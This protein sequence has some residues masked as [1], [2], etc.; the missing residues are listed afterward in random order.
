MSA[1][2]SPLS[3]PEDRP[4]SD[5]ILQILRVV[6]RVAAEQ[7]CPYIVVG[8]TARDLLLY[9]VYGIPASRA[10][11]DV[12]FA[13]AVESWDKFQTLRAALLATGEFA[14]SPV[15]HRL[16]FQTPQ[17]TTDIPID[18]I[19]FGGVAENDMIA[20]P[21]HRDT[22][23]TVAGFEDA[24]ASCVQVAVARDVAIPVVSLAALSV[25]K[26]IAWA[27]RRTSDKDALDLY[28]VISTYADAGNL[29]RLYDSAPGLLEN[30]GYDLEL[31][32]AALAGVDGR[33]LSSAPALARL[34]ILI[35]ESFIDA[36][37]ERIR[38]SRWPL[39]PE[40]LPRVRAIL[41]AWR[42]PLL[43]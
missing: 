16:F 6:D 27:D 34:R 38:G 35:T 4:V 36:L 25:L 9:H 29:D 32:G 28:R 40:L 5:P 15:E 31:A 20:W 22:L 8:A 2:S 21:P 10:T 37:A 19:P 42:D 23:M 18:L 41:Q 12:D 30:F 11:R 39:Q 14:P 33:Q 43:Q 13:M 1:S 24:M 3:V 17:G 7:A 26:V